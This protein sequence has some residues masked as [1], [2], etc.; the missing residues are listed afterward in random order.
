MPAQIG[1]A[2]LDRLEVEVEARVRKRG[3]VGRGLGVEVGAPCPGGLPDAPVQV[4]EGPVL[5]HEA[6][7]VVARGHEL[8][9][10]HLAA[11]QQ[12]DRV[13]GQVPRAVCQERAGERLGAARPDAAFERLVGEGRDA[14]GDP[15]G[16]LGDELVDRGGDVG[17]AEQPVVVA[18][19]AIDEG[20]VDAG[21]RHPFDG[22][23]GAP[24]DPRLHGDVV[25]VVRLDLGGRLDL[26]H[27]GHA[28][29]AEQQIGAHEHAAVAE[30]GLEQGEVATPRQQASG[31]AQGLAESGRLDQH[32]VG[33]QGAGH[34]ADLVALGEA[35][36]RGR[37]VD[38]ELGPVDLE[39]QPLGALAPGHDARLGETDGTHNRDSTAAPDGKGAPAG[40]RSA[41]PGRAQP[42]VTAA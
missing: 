36:L 18:V 38:D 28:A 24:R 40:S 20:A 9:G 16:D 11:R 8:V 2:E 25:D 17:L 14:A 31:V 27:A 41:G 21:Q 4:V 5:G 33:M 32:A 39:P 7:I 3:Q 19:A 35:P 37:R 6:Q 23:A 1:T 12:R 29:L 22:H 30:R 10:D 26:D 42:A 15:A 13:L 34:L